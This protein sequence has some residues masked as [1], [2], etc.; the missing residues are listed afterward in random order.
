MCPAHSSAMAFTVFNMID[1][2]AYL[3]LRYPMSPPEILVTLL[4]LFGK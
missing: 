2:F 1:I 3:F 4:L